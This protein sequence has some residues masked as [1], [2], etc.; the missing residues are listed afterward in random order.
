VRHY[1][2]NAPAASAPKEATWSVRLTEP[3]A[4]FGE[5][6]GFQIRE[7]DGD[8]LV[9][10]SEAGI[11]VWDLKREG[12]ERKLSPL[13]GKIVMVEREGSRRET[14][15]RLLAE[16]EAVFSKK[17]WPEYVS[18]AGE[19]VLCCRTEGVPRLWDLTT[20][21]T[22]VLEPPIGL[23]HLGLKGSSVL[24]PDGKSAYFAGRREYAVGSWTS[25]AG[26]GVN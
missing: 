23:I 2:W 22:T 7:M 18:A 6:Y 5:A 1:Q 8:R 10:G 20:G 13:P 3:R 12:M 4:I 16:G 19:R 14:L 9:I 24:S 21:E 25:R 11:E 17:V 15:D 26:R